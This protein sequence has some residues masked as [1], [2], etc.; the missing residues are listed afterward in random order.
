MDATVVTYFG[1]TRCGAVRF[2]VA[3][4]KHEASDCNCSICKKKG[5][6]HLIVPPERFT[7]RAW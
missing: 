6:L 2:L 1:G 7:L 4:D 3:V 5:F